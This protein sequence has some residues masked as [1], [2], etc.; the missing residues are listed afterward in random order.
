MIGKVDGNNE[1]SKSFKN[2][3]KIVEMSAPCL[4][5]YNMNY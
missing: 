4:A 3:F 5:D 2:N 1:E